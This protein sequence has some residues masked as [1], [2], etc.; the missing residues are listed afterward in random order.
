M[1]KYTR[2]L[3]LLLE[4]NSHMTIAKPRSLTTWAEIVAQTSYTTA[5]CSFKEWQRHKG[6]AKRTAVYAFTQVRIWHL[7]LRNPNDKWLTMHVSCALTYRVCIFLQS[8]R[9]PVKCFI[10]GKMIE[11]VLAAFY[12]HFCPIF[13]YIYL[14]NFSILYKWNVRRYKFRNEV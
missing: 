4:S 1:S 2:F 9:I 5:I 3:T 6:Y 12:P 8:L 14:C 10:E 13:F 7:K 11:L